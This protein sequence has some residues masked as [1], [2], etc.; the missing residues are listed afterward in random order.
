MANLDTPLK[1]ASGVNVGMPWR[2]PG[3]YPPTGTFTQGERQAVAY[4]YSGILAGPAA[5]GALFIEWLINARRRG[6]R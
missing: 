3:K 5:G 2:V 4:M 6:I 1:R